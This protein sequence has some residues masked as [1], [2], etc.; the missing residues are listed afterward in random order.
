MTYI[1]PI[2]F[3][4]NSIFNRRFIIL[5]KINIP[6]FE[7][8]TLTYYP[9][10]AI[11]LISLNMCVPNGRAKSTNPTFEKPPKPIIRII[12][13]KTVFDSFPGECRR[14]CSWFLGLRK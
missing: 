7:E 4:I 13:Y 8:F 1:E 14:C 3:G 5:D 11:Y 6:F 2:C 9:R 10:H 12:I